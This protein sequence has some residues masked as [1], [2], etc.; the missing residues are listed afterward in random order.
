MDSNA[1]FF[2]NPVFLAGMVVLYGVYLLR[3][4]QLDPI[5]EGLLGQGVRWEAPLL[6]ACVLL[7]VFA[8]VYG[9]GRWPEGL[10]YEESMLAQE[11]YALGLYGTDRFATAF[12]VYLW[13]WG[14]GQQ[15]ALYPYLCA[16]LMRAFGMSRLTL[17]LPMLLV[18]LAMLPVFWDLARRVAGR[19]FAL[20][21]FFLLCVNPYFMVQSHWVMECNLFAHCVLLGL[22]LLV[23]GQKHPAALYGAMLVFGLCMYAYAVSIY[24][25]PVLLIACAAYL[26]S[27]RRAKLRHILPCALLYT[28]V[29]LPFILVMAINTFGWETMTLGPFTLQNFTE[30]QRANDVAIFSGAPMRSM[31]ENAA[32]FVN[33]TFLQGM[34]SILGSSVPGYRTLYGFSI[35]PLALGAAAFVRD[36]RAKRFDAAH[37]GAAALV[38]IAFAAL[39]FGALMTGRP[40][41]HRVNA[42]Y[43]LLVLFLAYGLVGVCGRGRALPA[44]LC[45]VYLFSF[46][47]MMHDYTSP[48]QTERL[49]PEF[50]ADLYDA[51]CFVRDFP[52]EFDTFYVLTEVEDAGSLP[53]LL[54]VTQGLNARQVRLE[55]EIV[56]ADGSVIGMADEVYRHEWG[57]TFLPD[58]MECAVYA[59]PDAYMD[60]FPDDA[61]R[62]WAFGGY[63]ICYPIYWTEE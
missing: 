23:L 13:G 54:N 24:I 39:C 37:A 47:C 22:Y 2:A 41:L 42:V 8:R 63:H 30:N 61:Y 1:L 40:T 4:R 21:A 51:Q 59:V 26:L 45:A 17:R 11:A 50:H 58:E 48:A 53:Q 6:F 14:E 25:V 55:E 10:Y 18:N 38:L 31:L 32:L 44:A 20:C 56:R 7:G 60:A 35:V 3:R 34:D 5:G 15:A 62:R 19:R 57:E 16:P 9:F 33:V 28:L 43:Y 52:Y 46:G 49:E 12:P 36:V 27:T 29:A